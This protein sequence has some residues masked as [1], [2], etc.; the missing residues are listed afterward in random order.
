MSATEGHT[1]GSE[2][3]TSSTAPQPETT[4]AYVWVAP[5]GTVLAK[6]GTSDGAI[7]ESALEPLEVGDS[8]MSYL[9]SQL[10]LERS[11]VWELTQQNLELSRQVHTREHL[12]STGEEMQ[13]HQYGQHYDLSEAIPE[14]YFRR[15]ER[16]S[17]ETTS[18]EEYYRGIAHGGYNIELQENRGL[19]DDAGRQDYGYQEYNYLN[20]GALESSLHVN[21]SSRGGGTYHPHGGGY[22]DYAK[23]Y[24]F[25]PYYTMQAPMYGGGMASGQGNLEAYV[26]PEVR[27]DE[28]RLDA[29]GRDKQPTAESINE[30]WR[31]MYS[32]LKDECRAMAL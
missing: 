11:R 31:A 14:T 26:P 18:E 21:S 17:H 3:P 22:T 10:E 9:T 29:S 23:P 30:D 4:N 28:N 16:G 15:G 25:T 2:N 13:H 6:G 5:P 1:N 19:Y 8:Q 32:E 27:N 24:A 7:L 12:Q 20:R